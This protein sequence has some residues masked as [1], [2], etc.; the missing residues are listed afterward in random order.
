MFELPEGLI[1]GPREILIVLAIGASIG[2]AI[3]ALFAWLL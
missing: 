3:V 2:A 1:V